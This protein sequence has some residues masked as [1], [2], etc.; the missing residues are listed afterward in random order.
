M[1]LVIGDVFGTLTLPFTAIGW[2][3]ALG[4]LVTLGAAIVPAI[5][6]SNIS[7]MEALREA[8]TESKKPLGRRNVVGGAMFLLGLVA[9]FVRAFT[10]HSRSRTSTWAP[11]RCC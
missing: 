9:V 8:A 11:A 5:H 3:Y 10:P 7:P 1:T 4:L 6:A 2:S